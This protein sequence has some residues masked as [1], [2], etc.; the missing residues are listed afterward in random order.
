MP[1]TYLFLFIFTRPELLREPQSAGVAAPGPAS[2]SLAGLSLWELPA[3]CLGRGPCRRPGAAAPSQCP[4]TAPSPGPSPMKRTTETSSRIT[5]VLLWALTGLGESGVLAAVLAALWFLRG[6][7]GRLAGPVPCGSVALAGTL[8]FLEPWGQVWGPGLCWQEGGL[9][10][11]CGLTALGSRC[12]LGSTGGQPV[13]SA[14]PRL[15]HRERLWRT[16]GGSEC[17]SCRSSGGRDA[18][19]GFSHEPSAPRWPAPGGGRPAV[20]KGQSGLWQGLQAVLPWAYMVPLARG[21]AS[22]AVGAPARE[23]LPASGGPPGGRSVSWPWG[24]HLLGFWR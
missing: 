21:Q 24:R 7:L 1:G 6:S 10:K 12:A 17:H 19:P 20:A 5:F 13:V 14:R 18:L 2:A 3:S 16:L 9:A 11:R 4:C 22:G 15:E 23:T 8:S